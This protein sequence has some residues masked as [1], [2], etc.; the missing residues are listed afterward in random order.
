LTVLPFGYA[1]Q[2]SRAHECLKSARPFVRSKADGLLANESRKITCYGMINSLDPLTSSGEDRL[3]SHRECLKRPCVAGDFSLARSVP[4]R[5]GPREVIV[6]PDHPADRK[7]ELAGDGYREGW[8][9]A[10]ANPRHFRY[11]TSPSPLL[12][13]VEGLYELLTIRI[14]RRALRLNMPT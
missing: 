11:Y 3:V 13:G 9:F 8:V 14:K 2:P 10:N 4:R 1:A 5:G 7:R 12:E 6:L